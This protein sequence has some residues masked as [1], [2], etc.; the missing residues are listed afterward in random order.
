QAWQEVGAPAMN[1]GERRSLN[2]Q[3]EEKPWVFSK[4]ASH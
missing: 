1:P 4:D 2:L 3:Q